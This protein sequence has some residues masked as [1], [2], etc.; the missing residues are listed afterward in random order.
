MVR[1]ARGCVRILDLYFDEQ[2]P[3][4]VSADLIR[5]MHFSRSVLGAT[6]TPSFTML[7]DLSQTPSEMLSKMK[8]ETRYKI[9]RASER[10]ELSYEYSDGKQRDSILRF[11][12]HYDRYASLKR[13]PKVSR[14][15]YVILAEQNALDL[16]F[17]G[18][19]A[20][21]ILAASSCIRTSWRVRGL[22]LAA[23][24]RGTSNPSRRALI[25]RANRYLRWRDILRFR[26]A[27]IKTFDFGGWFAGTD[28]PDKLRVNDWKAEF[29]GEIV[30]E[31]VC[32]EAVTLKGRIASVAGE[33]RKH[34]FKMPIRSLKVPSQQE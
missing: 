5:Y 30:E 6:C 11:A 24:F 29:C 12:D 32:E 18:D 3:A 26:E 28:D 1:S 19:A 22:Q 2:K 31:F 16:S 4:D 25:G 7:L 20:G 9:R 21:E 15:R 14:R 10:D 34:L 8:N 27:G 33:L 23:A 17:V 13:L